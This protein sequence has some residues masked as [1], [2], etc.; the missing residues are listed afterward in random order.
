MPRRHLPCETP[1]GGRVVN[2]DMS[3]VLLALLLAAFVAFAANVK[4]YQKLLV[5]TYDDR[6]VVSA[7]DYQ[8][9]GQK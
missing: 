3:R 2:R 5:V 8:E 9:T 7:V 1:C 4:L 6:K